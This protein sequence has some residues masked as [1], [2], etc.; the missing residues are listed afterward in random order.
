MNDISIPI[1]SFDVSYDASIYPGSKR[2]KK[3]GNCQ[4]FVYDLLK[5]YGYKIPN[6][7]S[8]ELW[9]D[10]IY[11]TKVTKP[12]PLDILL[13]NKIKDAYGAHLAVY[14]GNDRIIHLSKEVGYP[15]I[16]NFDEF[17]RHTRYKVLVGIKRGRIKS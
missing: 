6:F 15:T 9:T 5:R 7:R 13:F 12:K 4:V 14:L 1:S 3:K 8:S 10:T 17:K 11:T 2:A 16:W